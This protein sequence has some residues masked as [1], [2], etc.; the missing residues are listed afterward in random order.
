MRSNGT[1]FWR[2]HVMPP[3]HVTQAFGP[4]K[5][6]PFCESTLIGLWMMGRPHM[7]CGTC[8]ADGPPCEMGLRNEKAGQSAVDVWNARP[9][10][11]PTLKATE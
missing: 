8:E 2:D 11:V 7:T 9:R 3:H 6:C 4:V 10:I 1:R 5:P